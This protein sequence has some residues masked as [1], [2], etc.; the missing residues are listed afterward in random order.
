M[1]REYSIYKTL[2]L[3]ARQRVALVLQPGNVW[4]IEKAMPNTEQNQENIQTC[5]MRGWIEVLHE[6]VPSG[7]I[8]TNGAL[9]EGKMFDGTKTIYKLTDS[10]WNAIHRTHVIG[11]LS[12]IV[13]LIGIA[14]TLIGLKP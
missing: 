8:E 5:L 11:F 3:L 10:G 7:S 1:K 6:S 13:S 12:V 14:I 9:V 4:V 2:T